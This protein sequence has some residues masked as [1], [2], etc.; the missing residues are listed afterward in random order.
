[1]IAT[2]AFTLLI[3]L[4]TEV[5]VVAVMTHR[6]RS[7]DLLW[8]VLFA[9]LLTHPIASSVIHGPLLYL[10]FTVTEA[11]VVL[12]EFMIYRFIAGLGTKPALRFA[13]IANAITIAFSLIFL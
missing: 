2:Y 12:C 6:S 4:V 11:L 10:G 1:M 5:A 8:T 7:K 3:T 9:N 13:I